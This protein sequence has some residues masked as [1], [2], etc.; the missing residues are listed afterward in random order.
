MSIITVNTASDVVN[1]N[2]GVTSSGNAGKTLSIC[3]SASSIGDLAALHD[4]QATSSS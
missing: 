3:R 2:D 4:A 1:A